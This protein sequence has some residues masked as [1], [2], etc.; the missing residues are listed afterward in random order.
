MADWVIPKIL[1]G[2]PM[3]PYVISLVI[4]GIVIQNH[5]LEVTSDKLCFLFI[6]NC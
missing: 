1:Y 5:D 3:E 4:Q 2:E 6:A